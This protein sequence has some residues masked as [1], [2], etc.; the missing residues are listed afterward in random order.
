MKLPL[1]LVTHT[2]PLI[3]LLT[4]TGWL[5]SQAS[6]ED[7]QKILAAAKK[8]QVAAHLDHLVNRIGPRLT[9]ST[10]LTTACEWARDTF[11]SF[12]LKARIEQWGTYPVGFDRGPWSGRMTKPEKMD[13]VF[14]TNAWTAGTKGLSKGRLLP[15]PA[16]ADEA[17]K[18]G[19]TMKGAWFLV[20]SSDPSRSG[21][22][23]GRDGRDGRGGRDG[24]DG[25]DGRGGRV[26][27]V[28]RG[29]RGG[30]GGRVARAILRLLEQ[31]GAAGIINRNGSKL[32]VTGGI[33][34]RSLSNVP[35]LPS[36][37]MYPDHFEKLAQLLED[38]KDVEVEFDIRNNFREGPIKLYNVVAELEGSK[39]PD[40]YVIVG[41]HIDSWDGATGTT[42][43]G[44]GVA[45]TIETARLIT[46]AG[47]KPL[48]T[49]RFMLWSGEEQGLQGSRAFIK[50]HPEEN[51]KVSAVLV[52]D[53]GTN[54]VA[55][56]AAMETMIPALETALAPIKNAQLKYP[57]TIHRISAFRPIGS[58]H[59]SYLGVGVPGFFWRQAGKAVY[60]RTHHTQYDTYESAIQDYQVHSSK[61]IA[62]G[63][64][65]I[66]NLP[67]KLSREGF[68]Y[69]SFRFQRPGG[70]GGG[71]TRRLLGVQTDGLTITQVIPGSAADKAGLKAEDKLV[72]IGKTEV[73][74]DSDLRRAIQEAPEQ[75]EIVVERDGK[76][77]TVVANFK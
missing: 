28:G 1:R 58:D 30:G 16:D 54:Y 8:P 4:L 11:K 20:P 40:E 48:R 56:I 45:T 23:D 7:T 12:G 51:A 18:L 60:Q 32:L 17:E 26:G 65:G 10:N 14:K 6:P 69:S 75:V 41:G 42:D 39:F 31:N 76:R 77:V 72:R 35:K 5:A 13:L 53:G 49:I 59:D 34:V 74:I 27:R 52:H 33:P 9:S 21:R 22:R 37:Q 15:L 2:R 25:R 67:E 57:F 50:A 63:A 73:T 62:L 71:N 46:A 24:R 68:R 36:V 29:G 19:A 64:V 55:G 70:Q 3:V 38:G 44:T 61:V 66:A 43:N 47:V